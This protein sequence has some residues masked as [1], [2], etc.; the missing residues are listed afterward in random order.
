MKADTLRKDAARHLDRLG[1]TDLHFHG[2]RHTTATAL[3]EAGC[4]SREIMA[5][6]GHQTEQMV[7]LYTQGWSKRSWPPAPSRKLERGSGGETVN[8]GNS[9]FG[10]REKRFTIVCLSRPISAIKSL[11]RRAFLMVGVEGLRT[12]DPLI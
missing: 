12:F 8:V 9:A 3:A 11:W 7:K 1:L 5:I 10:R 4:T 2:L 6:T